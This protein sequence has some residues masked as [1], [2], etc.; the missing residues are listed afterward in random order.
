MNVQIIKNNDELEWAVIPYDEYLTLV[1][2]AEMLVD[3][4]EFDCFQNASSSG[5][6]HLFPMKIVD[7]LLAGQNPIKVFREFQKMTQNE[8]ALKVGISIPYLSQLESGI[9]KGS[10]KVLSEISKALGVDLEM[11][12]INPE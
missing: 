11:I 9:R 1:E 10:I 3:I 12:L 6:E 2:K 4:Q 8:L 7:E 5:E